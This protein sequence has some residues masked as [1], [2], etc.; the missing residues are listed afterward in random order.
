MTTPRETY[1]DGLKRHDDGLANGTV[2]ALEPILGHALGGQRNIGGLGENPGTIPSFK[3]K[4]SDGWEEPFHSRDEAEAF[5]R[6][7]GRKQEA[8]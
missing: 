3:V 7:Y 4:T 8:A 1:A 5:L 6:Q 2:F